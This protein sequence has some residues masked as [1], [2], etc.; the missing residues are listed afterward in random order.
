MIAIVANVLN[1]DVFKSEGSKSSTNSLRLDF[2]SRE[3]LLL[4]SFNSIADFWS[5][6]LFFKSLI[7]SFIELMSESVISERSF[8]VIGLP[9]KYKTA[10][11]LVTR[12]ISDSCFVFRSDWLIFITEIFPKI[13]YI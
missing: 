12:S 6:Y 7:A 3:K 2:S 1:S 4:T 10:S 5:E 8:F 11:I 13:T 9:F